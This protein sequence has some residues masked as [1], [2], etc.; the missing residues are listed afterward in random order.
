MRRGYVQA[1]WFYPRAATAHPHV[2]PPHLPSQLQLV[3]IQSNHAWPPVIRTIQLSFSGSELLGPCLRNG[4]GWDATIPQEKK[5][6]Q[7]A[8]NIAP[9]EEELARPKWVKN[10]ANSTWC[11]GRMP[12]SGPVRMYRLENVEPSNDGHTIDMH[13]VGVHG[14]F[15]RALLNRATRSCSKPG[16]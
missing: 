12:A 13:G 10:G 4:G 8:S 16:S 9:L 7:F 6:L 3:E 11:R 1:P 15:P 5:H 2:L 14:A